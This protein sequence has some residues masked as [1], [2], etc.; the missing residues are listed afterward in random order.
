MT[1]S[2]PS[3]ESDLLGVYMEVAFDGLDG[4]WGTEGSK[5]FAELG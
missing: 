5:G 1:I 3:L 4:P 2:Q